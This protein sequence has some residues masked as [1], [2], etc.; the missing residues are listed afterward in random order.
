MDE[1]H[2]RANAHDG[3]VINPLPE[4][5]WMTGSRSLRS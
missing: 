2:S 4:K 5:P 1:G 3:E